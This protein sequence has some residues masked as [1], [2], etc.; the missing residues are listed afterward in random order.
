MRLASNFRKHPAGIF[1][2]RA[3]DVWRHLRKTVHSTLKVYDSGLKHLQYV[4]TCVAEEMIGCITDMRGKEFDPYDV[5][6]Q[7]IMNNAMAF[8]TGKKYSVGD[9]LFKMVTSLDLKKKK[10]FSP[11]GKPSKLDMFPWLRF[12]G[13]ETYTEILKFCQ[14]RD[15]IF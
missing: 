7:A 6:Y 12:L 10:L 11:I 2:S 8:L 4:S 5:F 15:A 14:E 9:E 1:H 3:D 13:N